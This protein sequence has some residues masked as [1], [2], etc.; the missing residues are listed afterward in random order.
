M[1][2]FRDSYLNSGYKLSDQGGYYPAK[3]NLDKRIPL[4]LADFYL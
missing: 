3:L 2:L 1:N 4:T